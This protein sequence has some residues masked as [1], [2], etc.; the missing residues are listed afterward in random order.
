M[1]ILKIDDLSLKFGGL[2]ALDGVN[3]QVQSGEI[4]GLIGPNGSGKSTLLNVISRIYNPNNGTISLNGRDLLKCKAHDMPRLG[5]GRTFQNLELF[6]HMTVLQNLMVS[7]TR[8]QT[9]N[10]FSAALF[11]RHFRRL[12]STC[13]ENAMEM[14]KLV[15][16]EKYQKRMAHDLSFGQQK[17]L[18][19]ARALVFR[20]KLLMLD[21]PAAGLSPVMIKRLVDIINHFRREN[22]LAVIVVEHMTKLVMN[23]A[24]RITL[25]NY[26]GVL[27]EGTPEEIRTNQKVIDVYLGR[28]MKEAFEGELEPS[29]ERVTVGESPK[30]SVRSESTPSLEPPHLPSQPREEVDG[31]RGLKVQG[32]NAFY[33]K[34]QV[35]YNLSIRVPQGGIV[36]LLGGNG[37]GKST[38]INAISGLVDVKTGTMQ[39]N[40]SHLPRKHPHK[41]VRMG[42][43]QVPQHREVFPYLNVRENL[44]MGAYRRRDRKGIEGDYERVYSYFP[45]LKERRKQLAAS[46]SGGEQQMLAIGRAL[47]SNPDMLLLDEPSAS[48]APTL[49]EEIFEKLLEINRDGATLFIVEQNV[50]AALSV[51]QYVYI[52]R[53]GEIVLENW[54]HNLKDNDKI[55]SSYFGNNK[56]P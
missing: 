25:L 28:G 3:M 11:T 21:E 37:S 33:G 17:L 13:Y 10:I 26:G 23:I 52:L 15:G 1:A 19:L 49:V 53:Q 27:A 2:K 44:A 45:R 38:T 51:A 9:Y 12:E 29:G 48:L 20:P 40:G 24:D 41:I 36:A 46:M 34:L 54:A 18:E 43:T 22:D 6:N 31:F 4:R 42:I 30:Y 14:L 8:Y 47:M 56:R 7:Q 50:D 32:I 55:I 39:Y 16:L 5:V 35:L